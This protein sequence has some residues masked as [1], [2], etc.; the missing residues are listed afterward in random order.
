MCIRKRSCFLF[1]KS[2]LKQIALLIFLAMFCL[3]MLSED[4][5]GVDGVNPYARNRKT[6]LPIWVTLKFTRTTPRRY[7]YSEHCVHK[8]TFCLRAYETD[9][10]CARTM[11]FF[12][13]TFQSYCTMD[14]V[15]C[16]ERYEL[17]QV[18][19]M[20]PCFELPDLT[21]YNEKAK[22]DF[23]TNDVFLDQTYVYEY[24]G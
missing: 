24:D 15:N 1:L 5:H 3:L 10:L 2:V 20:G 23:Y 7:N 4:K 11:Y 14:F 6:T 22:E 8:I 18:F 17:W 16:M 13:K 21:D 12:Y 19:H 9:Q